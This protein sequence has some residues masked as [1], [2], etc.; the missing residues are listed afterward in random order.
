MPDEL[1]PEEQSW[2]ALEAELEEPD[3]I[4]SNAEEFDA[5]EKAKK[6]G[7]EPA[8]REQPEKEE[9]RKPVKAKE[10][11]EGEAEAEAEAEGETE[12]EG[13]EGEAEPER[14]PDQMK[15]HIR[16]LN[17]ALR[18]A[19]ERER[20]HQDQSRRVLEAFR[21]RGADPQARQQPKGPEPVKLPDINEDPLGH[22]I[23]RIEQQQKII[24]QLARGGQQTRQ[25]IL[26]QR[27]ENQF[28]D[29][30]Q[31]SEQAFVKEKPDYW[32]ACEHLEKARRVEL[33]MMYPSKS[34]QVQQ[35]AQQQGMTVKQLHE[36]M[37]ARDRLNVAEAAVHQ[38]MNPAKY[39]YDLALTRGYKSNVQPLK[40]NGKE[41]IQA[42]KRGVK[43]AKTISGSGAGR[44]DDEMSAADLA[45]LYLEDPD[46]ADRIFDQMARKGQL[47]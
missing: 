9:E 15:A 17:G 21:N 27:Q 2:K 12:A 43:A 38:G 40:P 19:R 32:A 30:V 1:S 41:V 7:K 26:Q 31:A 36:A 45:D 5:A 28:W 16:N 44:G 24:E 39:Y 6:E 20:Y 35:Y 10:A 22:L 13:E 46:K 4:E 29:H 42:Q 3:L 33:E 11:K 37:L 25:E 34:Q 47:G 14:T 23:G 8:A 18:E